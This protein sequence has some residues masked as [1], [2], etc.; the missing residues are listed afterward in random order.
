MG[1]LELHSSLLPVT[2]YVLTK[3]PIGTALSTTSTWK[4]R[5]S[6]QVSLRC[7]AHKTTSIDP[8]AQNHCGQAQDH[9]S[10]IPGATM[11]TTESIQTLAPPPHAFT[12]KAHNQYHHTCSNHKSTS[13]LLGCYVDSEWHI[14]P[15]I[16]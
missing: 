3:Y 5:Q 4:F 16:T 13:N 9:H 10:H 14:N 6:L 8:L 1:T 15:W 7:C 11:E 12:Y 2:H